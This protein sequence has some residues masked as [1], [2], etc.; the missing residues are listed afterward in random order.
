MSFKQDL[1]EGYDPYNG[2]FQ[3]DSGT[4]YSSH[5]WFYSSTAIP[6]MWFLQAIG[7]NEL[8][9]LQVT[10]ALFI[11]FALYVVLFQSGF[12][13]YKKWLFPA[14]VLF[15]PAI[16][17]LGWPH[18]EILSYSLVVASIAFFTGKKYP[19]AVLCAALAST[20]N[21]PIIFLMLF[22]LAYGL[23]DVLRS[24]QWVRGGLLM[25]SSLPAFAPMIFYYINYGT[26]NLI[27]KTG[28]A[29]CAVIS[30]QRTSS[31]LFDLNQGLLPYLPGILIFFTFLLL[32]NWKQKEWRI[33][34]LALVIASMVLLAQTTTNWN[35]DAEGI[36]RYG[37]WMLPLFIWAIIDGSNLA[38]RTDRIFLGVIL[39]MQLIIV[40]SFPSWFFA[41]KIG[42]SDPSPYVENNRL[43]SYLL[44]NHPSL[45]NPL[46]EIFLERTLNKEVMY[47]SSDYLPV[48]YSK[49]DGTV[50][51]IMT[52]RKGLVGLSS[53]G[54]VDAGFLQQ[55]KDRYRDEDGVYYLNLSRG[56][57]KFT[58]QEK[59]L[60]V[61][62]AEIKVD[63]QP[64]VMMP[65]TAYQLTVS[66]KNTGTEAWYSLGKYPIGL[67]YHLFDQDGNPVKLENYRENI[68]HRVEPGE[69][70]TMP[71]YLTTPD[72]PGSYLVQFD[73][74]QENVGWFEDRGNNTTVLRI[75]VR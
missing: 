55:Q 46:P 54:D 32:R 47:D 20:Q 4:H 29:S 27:F 41:Q 3:T 16:W 1:V 7:Q 64:G 70:I 6:A 73:L 24:K 28:G 18:P 26:P 58:V 34:E 9:A 12:S 61:F 39:V 31:F 19:L 45:Y 17:Y 59:A 72:R 10:N 53:Y 65:D 62:N 14:F 43:A 44:D 74:V 52:D 63:D 21:P 23:A 71:I 2:Y 5:F 49:T 75:E 60:S 68:R 38:F 35:S 15:C 48:I 36:M 30:F 25:A 56:E 11:I 13:K 69:E 50:T 8:L 57:M 42:L 67:S 40:L 37:V 22:A 66:I 51:K 33:Y